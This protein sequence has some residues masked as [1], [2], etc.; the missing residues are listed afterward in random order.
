MDIT[1]GKPDQ[2]ELYHLYLECFPDYSVQRELF[3]NLLRPEKAIVACVYGEDGDIDGY[4]MIHDSSIAI[5]CVKPSHRQKG[6]GSRLLDESE[7]IVAHAGAK[8]VVLGRGTHYL[9]Q[10]V[11]HKENEVAFFE[12]RGYKADWVSTNMTLKLNEFSPERLDVPS[13][14]EGVLFRFAA[15]QDRQALSA[16][17]IDAHSAWEGIFL[18]CADP[19]LLA[20]KGKEIVGFEIL[21]PNGGRFAPPDQKVGAIGCVGVIHSERSAGIGRQMVIQGA[22]WLKN[23]RCHSIELRYVELVDWYKKIGFV[24]VAYQWMGEKALI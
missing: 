2:N 19:V 23:Q 17:V 14:P 11:P 18:D 15:E 5:L 4:S 8:R 3:F 22:Q 13:L 6:L 21:S 1:Y 9:L 16:A 10:G 20:V 12:K 7:R 24:P